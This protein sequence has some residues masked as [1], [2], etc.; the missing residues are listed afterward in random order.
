MP[1][2][3]PTWEK[4]ESRYKEMGM[5]AKEM[6]KYKMAWEKKHKKMPKPAMLG[7]GLAAGA[8]KQAL[9]RKSKLEQLAAELDGKEF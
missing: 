2:D 9:S 7:K 3:S 1:M 8:A 5:S 6:K 4:A